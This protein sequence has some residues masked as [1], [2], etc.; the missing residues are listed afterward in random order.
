MDVKKAMENIKL[1]IDNKNVRDK[2][3]KCSSKKDIIELGKWIESQAKQISK[4]F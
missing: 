4:S 3:K 1:N 2:Y